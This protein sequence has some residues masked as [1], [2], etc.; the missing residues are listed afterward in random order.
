MWMALILG[1]ILSVVFNGE[2][3]HPYF[4][5]GIVAAFFLETLA[6]ILNLLAY[7]AEYLQVINSKLEDV[8]KH[9]RDIDTDLK[10]HLKVIASDVSQICKNQNLMEYYLKD[11]L[12]AVAND[13]HHVKND[14]KTIEFQLTKR[15]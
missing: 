14:L 2:T 7:I 5:Y 13:M 3:Q 4:I 12:K 6:L 10:N 9:Q 8:T 15:S 11:S 1:I